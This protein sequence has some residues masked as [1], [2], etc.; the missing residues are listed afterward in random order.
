MAEYALI[1]SENEIKA[2]EVMAKNA[3]DSKFFHNLN[4]FGG[5]F[6]IALYARELGLPPMQCLFGGMHNIQGKIEL[7]ARLMNSM[8]RK[9]GHRIEIIESSDTKCTLKGSRKDSG[10]TS[11]ISFS[12]DDAKRAGIYREGS[13]WTKWPSDMLFARALSR[14]ARRLFPDIIG[15]AYVE[16]ELSEDSPREQPAAITIEPVKEQPQE[17]K[18]STEIAEE[19]AA[20]MKEKE[21]PEPSKLTEYLEAC[22]KK[23]KKVIEKVMEDG[24]ENPAKFLGFYKQWL[25]LNAEKIEK[26]A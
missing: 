10:E 6:S 7:S 14:L 9:A 13:G 22:A 18:T 19:F 16:G 8:I 21:A 17:S 23:G 3:V 15:T 12:L 2:I 25:S 11:T 5:I 20:V 26:T 4:G 24:I 1:P